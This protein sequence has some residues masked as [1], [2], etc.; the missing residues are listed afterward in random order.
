MNPTIEFSYKPVA[1]LKRTLL[2]VLCLK[3]AIM[4]A[5]SK[6]EVLS[7]NQLIK[8]KLEIAENINISA[9]FQ[10]ELLFEVKN[11]AMIESSPACVFKDL[12]ILSS[13]HKSFSNSYK[14]VIGTKSSIVD[15]N[16]NQLQISFEKYIFEIR[17]YDEG[18]GYCFIGND[19]TEIIIMNELMSLTFASATPIYF[20]EETSLL[21]HNE[22]LFEKTELGD[23]Q[24][25]KFCSL[26]MLAIPN[27]I[28][29]LVTESS[30]HNYPGLWLKKSNENEFVSLFPKYPK[31]TELIKDRNEKVVET[32]DFIAKTNAK[33]SF[34]WRIFA[35]AKE[36]AELLTNQLVWLLS[37]E[38]VLEETQWIKPG[39]VAWD[40]W[41]ANNIYDV[42]FEA[43]INTKTYKYYIDFASEFGLEY[44]ILDEGWYMLGNLLDVVPEMDIKELVEYAS[45]K[46]VGIILWVVWKTL[47]EQLEEALEQFEQWGIK[48][49][50]VDFMQ[51]DDQWMVN[52]Y[53]RIAAAAA[54]HKLL[55]N[56]HG[57]YKPAGLHRKYPNVLTREGVKGLEHNK[58]A[59]YITPEHDLI[60]PFTRMVAGPMDYT[61]GAMIN[62][63]KGNHAIIFN[64]PMSQGT[65][66]HQLAMYVIY[67]SPLQML[68]DNPS[69]YIREREIM[70]FLG[71]VP[72]VWDKTKIL[73]A[74]IG[75][76]IISAREH[77]SEWYVGAMNNWTAR[78]FMIDL[79]FLD[80]GKR[81]E[82]HIFSDG[83]NADRYG[84][85]YK[86]EV[87][88]VNSNSS[89]KI[90]MAP[91]GG[92]V[93]RII[94]KH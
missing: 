23:I 80:E 6:F 40:W 93:A 39:K 32:E 37:E 48:G 87:V 73:E 88:E 85:D 57:S 3:F 7:P 34:P 42:D 12:R 77:A 92:W 30:L 51:R 35:I 4:Q 20:P 52:Y 63:A 38:N 64:Q 74:K 41:N 49:I 31:K 17:V 91:G 70:E 67:E 18:I 71:P 29:V 36:D 53:E 81:Y 8:A 50:K 10:N 28:N 79:S 55:V 46:N 16:Y 62:A 43:G 44:I 26:P 59:D 69:N 86:K 65:R 22:R 78:S 58:W 25:G 83:R 2:L 14:P 54:K 61:P 11:I 24:S 56:F 66:T 13:E 9:Y 5:N 21:S 45:K 19:D 72:T 89:L 47:D 27:N 76:Y 60:L 1:M 82:A 84:S 75:E 94:P 33:R 15:E 68:A 90:N